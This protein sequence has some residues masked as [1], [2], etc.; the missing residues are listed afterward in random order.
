MPSRT[1]KESS[2]D[3]ALSRNAKG[4]LDPS[5]EGQV[6][7]SEWGTLPK[8][9]VVHEQI[10]IGMFDSSLRQLAISQ[11]ILELCH[12][13]MVYSIQDGVASYLLSMSQVTMPAHAITRSLSTSAAG[14]SGTI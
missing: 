2:A 8:T 14:H 6:T 11:G 3:D 9:E 13:E 1:C 10:G 7:R 12:K 5:G 4:Y